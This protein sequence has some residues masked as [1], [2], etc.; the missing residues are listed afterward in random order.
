MKHKIKVP[1]T[2]NFIVYDG[3]ALPIKDFDDDTLKLICKVWTRQLIRKA[4]KIKLVE[5]DKTISY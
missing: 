2:P 4:R 1:L 5:E 3:H